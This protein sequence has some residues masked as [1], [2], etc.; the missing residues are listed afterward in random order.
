MHVALASLNNSHSFDLCACYVGMKSLSRLNLV[1]AKPLHPRSVTWRSSLVANLNSTVS[2]RMPTIEV[3]ACAIVGCCCVAVMTLVC[4]FIW[5]YNSS[6]LSCYTSFFLVSPSLASKLVK[7]KLSLCSSCLGASAKVFT[8]R[9]TTW[10]TFLAITMV[11]L[12]SS[13]DL[14][15]IMATAVTSCS[16]SWLTVKLLAIAK[17]TMF[18]MAASILDSHMSIGELSVLRPMTNQYLAN[19]AW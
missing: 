15:L 9:L 12:G 2:G 6:M 8:G 16:I 18:S 11:H 7:R 19:T 14:A 4:S 1:L 13:K 10:R 3:E 5:P 17:D